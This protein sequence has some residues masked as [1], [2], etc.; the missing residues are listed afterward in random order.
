[1]NRPLK[2]RGAEERRWL[3]YPENVRKVYFS[4]WIVCA[5]LLLLELLIDKHAETAAE[6]WFGFHGFFGLIACVG[7]V[8]A[9]KLL[10]R[11]ISR[12]EDYYDHR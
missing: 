5:V 12:P 2:Q 4:V 3:D 1:M 10:R 8:L 7:L 11:V 6:H 9:A